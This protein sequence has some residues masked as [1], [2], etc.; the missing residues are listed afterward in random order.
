MAFRS[1]C[2]ENH[3][4]IDADLSF[5]ARGPPVPT[6]VAGEVAPKAQ[7]PPPEQV[8]VLEPQ[9][10]LPADS[11]QATDAQVAID[12]PAGED[13]TQGTN[14]VI[15]S[16]PEPSS[17]EHNLVFFRL[18]DKPQ[19]RRNTTIGPGSYVHVRGFF[20]CTFESS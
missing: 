14:P 3:V 17:D 13:D 15:P 10:E 9:D 18:R 2:E 6:Q 12:N 1:F 16:T 20:I 7:I 19:R 5:K 11:H 4:D 8:E